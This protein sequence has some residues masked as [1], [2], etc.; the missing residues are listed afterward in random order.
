M[1]RLVVCFFGVVLCGI[2]VT[3]LAAQPTN[4]HNLQG[5]FVALEVFVRGDL[6]A[7]K[8]AIDHA[9]RLQQRTPGLRVQIHD[10][11]KD[12]SQ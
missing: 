6:P 8:Q 4:P 7:S 2:A 5:D 3:P 12:R 11:E 9:T 10:V 1:F